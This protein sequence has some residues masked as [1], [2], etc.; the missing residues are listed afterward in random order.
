MWKLA[1][2][3]SSGTRNVRVQ[4]R[5]MNTNWNTIT[6]YPMAVSSQRRFSSQLMSSGDM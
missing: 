1:P 5:K 4:N 2:N 3:S 6:A